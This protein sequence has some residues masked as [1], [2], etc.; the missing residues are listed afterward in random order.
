MLPGSRTSRAAR[1]LSPGRR[2]PCGTEAAKAA[3]PSTP[4]AYVR[5]HKGRSRDRIYE[6]RAIRLYER[7]PGVKP[8]C[9]GGTERV[10]ERWSPDGMDAGGAPA[11]W[12]LMALWAAG[13]SVLVWSSAHVSI[14]SSTFEDLVLSGLAPVAHVKNGLSGSQGTTG[15]F[16]SERLERLVAAQHVDGLG[17]L[18]G[19]LDLRDLRAALA[20][21]AALGAL[22]A[23]FEERVRGRGDRRLHQPPPQISGPVLGQRAAAVDLAGLFMRGHRPVYPVSLTGEAKRAMSPISAAIVKAVTQPIPGAVISSGM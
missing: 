1:T 23:L 5:D 11:G 18:A 22:V 14:A 4:A 21:Q 20:T 13:G 17:Q 16:R 12:V 6:R 9:F 8:I 10:C 19:E 7:G 3:A 15:A 2:R